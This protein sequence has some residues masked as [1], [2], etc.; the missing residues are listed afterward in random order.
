MSQPELKPCPFC[1]EHLEIYPTEYIN[2][3][4]IYKCARCKAQ[5]KKCNSYDDAVL[6]WNKRI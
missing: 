4:V 1:G 2:L 5:T 3:K 6:A